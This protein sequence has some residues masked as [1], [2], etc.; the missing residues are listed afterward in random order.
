MNQMKMYC[1]RC[2]RVVPL[3]EGGSLFRTG[4]FKHDIP[5]GICQECLPSAALPSWGKE[6][7]RRESVLL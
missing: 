5:M 6:N 4:Y 2:R 3:K 1:I 7:L